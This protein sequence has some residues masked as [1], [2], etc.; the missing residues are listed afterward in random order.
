[1]NTL[2][3]ERHLWI[4]IFT[5]SK[6]MLCPPIDLEKLGT[7]EFEKSICQVELLERTWSDKSALRMVP[8][9]WREPTFSRARGSPVAIMGD[10]VIFWHINASTEQ[11]HFIWISLHD[12]DDA[13]S[14]PINMGPGKRTTSYMDLDTGIF[15]IIFPSDVSL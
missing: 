5:Q 12:W 6:S 4:A 11:Q 13:I 7:A 14:F 10:Y 9:F 8:D 15:Y 1:M 3:R 2:S